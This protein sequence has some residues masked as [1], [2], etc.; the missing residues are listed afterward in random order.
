MFAKK[1]KI[2]TASIVVLFVLLCAHPVWA[3]VYEVGEGMVYENIGDVPWE[4]LNPG[5]TVRIHYRTNP[6]HEKWVIART[7]TELENIVIQGAPGSGGELPVID[8][9][10]AVTRQQL[11]YWSEERGVINIGGSNTPNQ[12]PNYIVIENLEIKSARPPYT[13]TNDQ[14]NQAEYA[15]NASSFYVIEGSHITIRN[16]ILHNCGNGFFVSH[17]ACDILVEGCHFYDNGIEGSGYHHNNYTEAKGIT[18]Q[19]NHFGLLRSGCDGNNL[20]DRSCGTVIRYNWIEGGNRQLDLVDADHSE[21]YN[22]PSYNETY[23][24]GNII[25][26]QTNEGNSQLCHYGGDSGNMDYY[27][28]G[29]LYFYNNTVISKRSTNTTLLRLSTNEESCDA[30]NNI[31]Y[32]TESGNKLAMLNSHGILNI[33]N[34]WF[35]A[36]WVES[37]QG[38]S[39]QGTVIDSGGILT[40]DLPGFADWNSEDYRLLE[41]S[42]CVDAGASLI[43]E[44]LPDHNVI[45]QYIKH[46]L[47]EN[48][49]YDETFDIGA[50]EYYKGSTVVHNNSRIPDKYILQQNYPNPFNP[51]TVIGYQLSFTCSVE[52]IIYNTL[53]QRIKTLVNQEQNAGKYRVKFDGSGLASGI[54]FYQLLAF[55]TSGEANQFSKKRKMILLR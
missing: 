26:E 52:L 9:E 36:G 16:C 42:P 51:E 18:F 44:A 38:G 41:D 50:Y 48:R 24:Y 10:N 1:I 27:R 20:K 53:G 17:A 4:S 22:D 29:I 12:T 33:R 55:T 5:D 23:V 31:V 7:G 46:C 35:K 39:Y 11:N 19:Y 15:S 49:P 3:G 13:F 30:R 6:Y 47:Y 54:Y 45:Y 25:I 8:G 28:K 37:H 14:G 21:I 40:G 43:A 32:T 34:N 2:Y